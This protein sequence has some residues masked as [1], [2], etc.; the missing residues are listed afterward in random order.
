MLGSRAPKPLSR[1]ERRGFR[2][3]DAVTDWVL[4]EQEIGVSTQGNVT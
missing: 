2:S 3:G 1:A 4:S